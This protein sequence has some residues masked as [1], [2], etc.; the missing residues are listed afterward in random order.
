MGC[1]LRLTVIIA[2]NDASATDC[3]PTAGTISND[4]VADLCGIERDSNGISREKLN[5]EK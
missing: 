4:S 3:E 5:R 1:L 2:R